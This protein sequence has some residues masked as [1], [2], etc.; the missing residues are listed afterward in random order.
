M[1]LADFVHR[2]LVEAVEFGDT[3]VNIATRGEPRRAKLQFVVPADET[4]FKLAPLT[5]GVADPDERWIAIVEKCWNPTTSWS[6]S[7]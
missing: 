3:Y 5:T 6:R 2:D 7:P 4:V 1:G